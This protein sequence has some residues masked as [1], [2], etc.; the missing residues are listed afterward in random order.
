M[1]W[2]RLTKRLMGTAVFGLAAVTIFASAC[3][4]AEG[5]FYIQCTLP[6]A[7]DGTTCGCEGTILSEGTYNTAGCAVTDT[8]ELAGVCGYT[9]SVVFKSGMLS[10]KD[11]EANL[12][13]VE[14]SEIH[15]DSIDVTFESTGP[16]IDDLIGL[17]VFGTLPPDGNLCLPLNLLVG[18]PGLA[19]GEY[20]NVVATIKGYGRTTGGLEVETPEVFIP[21]TIY[22]DPTF[23]TCDDAGDT[24]PGLNGAPIKCLTGCESI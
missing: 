13:R 8:G 15:V 7:G 23:C 12:N 18:D 11:I 2:S 21:F 10:S 4:E 17:T 1:A 24:T 19:P 6:G 16:A 5:R 9:V 22:N 3:A 20:A 14:T